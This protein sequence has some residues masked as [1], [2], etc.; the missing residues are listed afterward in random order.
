MKVDGGLMMANLHD[1]PR[2]ARAVEACGYD[3]ILS[4]EISSDP[5]LPLLLAAEHTERVELIT[6]IA[7]AF[8]RNPMLLANMGHDLN[9]YSKGR[10]ILGIGSQIKPHITRRFSMPW[11]RPAARMREFILA[12]RAIWSSWYDGVPLDFQGDFY[13]HTLMTPMFTPDSIAYGAPRVFLAAV[14]PMMAEVAGE[15]A[16][17]VIAHAFTTE[18]YLREV[19]LPALQRG[20]DKSGRPRSAVQ[21][22]CPL[23][24]V[25]GNTEEEYA[26]VRGAVASQLAFYASTPAYRPVLELHGWGDLQ[27]EMHRL[28]RE[29][30]WDVMGELVTDEILEEFAIVAE[31]HKVAG[32]LKAR[33]G[34]IVDRLGCTFT[35]ATA[36]QRKACLEELRGA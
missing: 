16:D 3:G 31:P 6:S 5:F 18:R 19:T 15:V 36:E 27:T 12:M 34:G 11:S 30:R 28:T 23:F 7:V 2:N 25:T 24:V 32:A 17:G 21:V 4:A 13:N 33:F 9:D 20:L 10:F 8:A 1:V 26:Q 14:G 35:F 22:A 29:G